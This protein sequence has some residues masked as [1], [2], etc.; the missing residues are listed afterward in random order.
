MGIPIDG[1]KQRLKLDKLDPEILDKLDNFTSDKKCKTPKRTILPPYKP[2]NDKTGKNM[3]KRVT[4]SMLLSVK[5]NSVKKNP[6]K[7]AKSNKHLNPLISLDEIR[8]KL[9]NLNKV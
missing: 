6:K 5:L 1:V 8:F 3:P 2:D 4:L 9:K 7:T